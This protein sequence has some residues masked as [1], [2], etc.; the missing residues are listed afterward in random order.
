[1]AHYDVVIQDLKNVSEKF[2]LCKFVTLESSKVELSDDYAGDREIG[3]FMVIGLDCLSFKEHTEMMDITR[4]DPKFKKAAFK[5]HLRSWILRIASKTF[6]DSGKEYKPVPKF[7][8][9]VFF[10]IY[11]CRC[12]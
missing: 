4:C 1:M 2:N 3:N 9:I 11:V 5:F 7:K 10:Q 6:I 8:Q 12:L